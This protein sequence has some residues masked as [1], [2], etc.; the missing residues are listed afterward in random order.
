M[1]I[2]LW[3][4]RAGRADPHRP[5]LG[6]GPNV[7]LT[8]GG[9]AERAARLAGALIDDWGLRAGDRVAVIAK[10]CPEYVEVLY[11]V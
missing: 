3:L 8:Y 2:A 6:R 4:E 10:N 7:V 5:A 9:L 1:N 11:G